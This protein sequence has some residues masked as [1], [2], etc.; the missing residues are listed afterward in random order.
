MQVG[1]FGIFGVNVGDEAAV[2]GDKII[3]RA[4][5]S[6]VPNQAV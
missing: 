1:K 5:D 4:S 6:L 2:I 3:V